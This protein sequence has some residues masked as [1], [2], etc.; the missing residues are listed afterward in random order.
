MGI[1]PVLNGLVKKH[2]SLQSQLQELEKEADHIEDGMQAIAKAILV[3]E[4]EYPIEDLKPIRRKQRRIVY[5]RGDLHRL[6]GNYLKT[7]SNQFT[8]QDVRNYVLEFGDLNVKR[9]DYAYLTFRCT[10]IL[11][12]FAKMGLIKEI[13]GTPKV[14]G[15]TWEKAEIM[16]LSTLR[17]V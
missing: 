12:N 3:I 13:K 17:G 10:A 11:N 9:S 14:Q 8:S 6:V 15:I 1:S 2:V 7:A 4:P 5:R 16:A